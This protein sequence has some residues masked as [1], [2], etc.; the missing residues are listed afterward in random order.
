MAIDLS[1][2]P[3]NWPGAGNKKKKNTCKPGM[4]GKHLRKAIQRLGARRQDCMETIQRT[5]APEAFKVPGSMK[6]R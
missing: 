5:K 6:W 3:R 2:H 4:N 1:I